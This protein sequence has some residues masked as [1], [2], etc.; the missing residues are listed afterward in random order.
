M[1][2]SNE[3]LNNGYTH[4]T[5]N[6]YTKVSTGETFVIMPLDDIPDHFLT[7]EPEKY[8]D[9]IVKMKEGIDD[10]IDKLEKELKED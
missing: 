7:I 1:T 6:Y 8:E 9:N 4:I 2:I 5:E 3:E 10:F